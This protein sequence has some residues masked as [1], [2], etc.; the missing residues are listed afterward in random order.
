MMHFLKGLLVVCL[1]VL[2][3][4]PA[5]AQS[6]E[7]PVEVFGYFQ[8]TAEF[9][10]DNEH[11]R[12]D[13]T[14][15]NAQQLNILFRKELTSRWSS[16][17]NVEFLNSFS[18]KENLGSAT[19]DE[20]WLRYRQNHRFDLRLGLLVPR[21][22]NLNEIKNRTP[23]LP[24]AIRPIVYEE[25]FGDFFELAEYVPERAF[26][27]A[28]G[29][30]QMEDLK[31]DYALFLGNSPNLIQNGELGQSGI[32]STTT[33]L[34]GARVGLR[35]NT[36]RLGFSGTRDELNFGAAIA[37]EFGIDPMQ[38]VER[39]RYR[40]GTDFSANFGRWLFEAEGIIVRYDFDV[41][42]LKIQRQFVYATL[43]Y[44]A[45]EH[46]FVYGT[47]WYIDEDAVAGGLTEKANLY[48]YSGG[49]SYA[50][51]DRITLKAQYATVKI[52]H[53]LLDDEGVEAS[54]FVYK[55]VA[56]VSVLF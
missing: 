14:S 49:V 18:S 6:S 39:P 29:F 1:S 43:G 48:V 37:E 41:P 26:V 11:E 22:N 23:L 52:D 36:I 42:S 3:C 12:R 32:D 5:F 47:Y 40:W 56:A 4:F 2:W 46:L 30:W 19:L 15:F 25:S 34:V 55:F 16:F 38:L 28:M 45:T 53:L 33:F 13:N 10:I 8:T 27:Q 50:L 35:T 51:L 54:G 9:S 31:L 21:F 20:A 24:Y 44:Y 7:E 17:I